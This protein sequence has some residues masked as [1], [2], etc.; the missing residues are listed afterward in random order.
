M[1]VNWHDSI[2]NADLSVLSDSE[3][4]DRL[5]SILSSDDS[6]RNGYVEYPEYVI[7]MRNSGLRGAVQSIR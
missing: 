6:N 2:E 1:R 7:A 4:S 5:D 3:L